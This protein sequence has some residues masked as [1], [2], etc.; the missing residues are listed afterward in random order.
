MSWDYAAVIRDLYLNFSP[1][2]STQ[3]K[4]RLLG[5]NIG[6]GISRCTA[7]VS[8]SFMPS[9]QPVPLA[10]QT[11][12]QSSRDKK[13]ND[14]IDVSEDNEILSKKGSSSSAAL[15][16]KRKAVNPK[17]AEDLD[18][19]C[20]YELPSKPPLFD[21]ETGEGERPTVS[22]LSL[23]PFSFNNFM[24][25]PA[26][27]NSNRA[28]GTSPLTESSTEN[29]T[30][31]AVVPS[32][33]PLKKK[34]GSAACEAI[35]KMFWKTIETENY[36]Q[37]FSRKTHRI[38]DLALKGGDYSKSLLSARYY[39]PNPTIKNCD[40]F[41]LLFLI[42]DVLC[43]SKPS[44]Y[45]PQWTADNGNHTINP[46]IHD[47]EDYDGEDVP[48]LI[49]LKGPSPRLLEGAG[50]VGPGSEIGSGSGSS[51]AVMTDGDQV[52]LCAPTLRNC[53]TDHPNINMDINMNMDMKMNSDF[54]YQVRRIF[55]LCSLKVSL[56][57][58][59]NSQ[60]L[61]TFYPADCRVIR[62]HLSSHRR[63][64][65]GKI[66]HWNPERKFRSPKT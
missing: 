57:L 36:F 20:M 59:Y 42:L 7:I 63:T 2:Q 51:S 64:F 23:P 43:E 44:L 18:V 46:P 25:S 31:S 29:Q 12:P 66:I 49:E 28:D 16:R 17:Q 9:N 10:A 33:A 62:A 61:D 13:K 65:R 56:F 11:G 35:N 19:D 30:T 14:D 48:I 40:L 45:I 1:T 39:L 58:R 55:F 22:E 24:T 60:I 21:S 15:K 52:N 37:P 41:S 5:T 6:V 27:S 53:T 38:D 3:I 47:S 4:V 32:A 8:A 54:L 50:A 34:N 26:L